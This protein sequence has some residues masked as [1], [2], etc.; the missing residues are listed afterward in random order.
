MMSPREIKKREKSGC[1]GGGGGGGVVS[2]VWVRGRQTGG[3]AGHRERVMT[4]IIGGERD[5]TWGIWPIT[6]YMSSKYVIK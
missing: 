1:G 4:L 6:D 3:C 5:L 2:G